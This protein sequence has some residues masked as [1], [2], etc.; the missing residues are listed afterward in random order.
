MLKR[1]AGSRSGGSGTSSSTDSLTHTSAEPPHLFG[2][3]KD[4]IYITLMI[5]AVTIFRASTR[6]RPSIAS[7]HTPASA[8]AALLAII[9]LALDLFV[10]YPFGKRLRAPT[11]D[12]LTHKHPS[13]MKAAAC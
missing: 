10:F 8:A 5:Y 2:L 4:F 13:A 12:P 1:G 9:F 7:A 3:S 6:S 11:R